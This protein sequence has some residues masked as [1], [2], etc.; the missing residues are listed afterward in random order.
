MKM[1]M[2]VPVQRI[3]QKLVLSNPVSGPVPGSPSE[4]ASELKLTN[5]TAAITITKIVLRIQINMTM[6]LPNYDTPFLFIKDQAVG[7]YG[8]PE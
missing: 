6:N 1:A 4:I 5:R 7:L 8:R 2:A 3:T